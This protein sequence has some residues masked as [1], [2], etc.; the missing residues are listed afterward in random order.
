MDI[1]ANDYEPKD[2]LKF[3][4]QSA[5]KTQKEFANDIGKSKDWVQSNEIGRSDYK[6]K[7]LMELANKNNIEIR[8]KSKDEKNTSKNK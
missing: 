2:I 7:D 4:R 3:I 8:I 1:K 5:G 6:F